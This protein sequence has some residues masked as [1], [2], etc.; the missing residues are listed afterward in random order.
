LKTLVNSNV[1]WET[2]LAGSRP[3]TLTGRIY[4][5]GPVPGD[6]ERSGIGPE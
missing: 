5:L 3:L 6:G 1:V 2:L 4:G